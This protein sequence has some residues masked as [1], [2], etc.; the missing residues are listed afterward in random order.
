VLH[1]AVA[2]EDFVCDGH[3]QVV[4]DFKPY[5]YYSGI[6]IGESR[7][8]N[9]AAGQVEGIGSGDFPSLS[10]TRVTWKSRRVFIPIH[11]VKG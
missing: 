9:L 1:V 5:C 4:L 3:P 10:N 8:L 6:G 7:S 2:H 11:L